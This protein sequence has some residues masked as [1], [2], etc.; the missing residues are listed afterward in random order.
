MNNNRKDT[1]YFIKPQ[2]W[3]EKIVNVLNQD[4]VFI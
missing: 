4:K 1:N 2:N 3:R